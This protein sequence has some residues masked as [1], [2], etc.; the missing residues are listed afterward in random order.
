MRLPRPITSTTRPCLPGEDTYRYLYLTTNVEIIWVCLLPPSVLRSCH[1]ISPLTVHVQPANER[2]ALGYIRTAQAFAMLGVVIAQVMRLNASSSPDPVLG[3]LVV[4]VP[5]SA[6]CHV[7][8]LVITCLGFYRFLHWQAELARGRAL[9]G[10]WEMMTIF[11]LSILVSLVSS[12][13]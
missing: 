2:T 13:L 9:S 10:G 11:V 5:L 4:S 3:F 12:A 1:T 6:I 8:A 7:M